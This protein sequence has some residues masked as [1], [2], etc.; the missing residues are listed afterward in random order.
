MVALKRFL[1]EGAPQPQD[2]RIFRF[3]LQDFQCILKAI[4]LPIRYHQYASPYQ[5]LLGLV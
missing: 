1:E 2:G 5:S 4:N 3:I